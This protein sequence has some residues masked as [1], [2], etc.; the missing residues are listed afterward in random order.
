M[1]HHQIKELSF[2]SSA[3]I[4]IDKRMSKNRIS[5]QDIMSMRWVLESHVC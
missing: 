3:N 2:S 1:E 5:L 4:D